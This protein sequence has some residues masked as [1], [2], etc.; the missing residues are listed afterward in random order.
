MTNQQK[1]I[2]L[3]E[4]LNHYNDIEYMIGV[5]LRVAQKTNDKQYE[6]KLKTDMEKIFISKD[7]IEA[8]IKELSQIKE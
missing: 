4:E 5:R 2:L 1:L 6:S 3:S 7:V 8:E